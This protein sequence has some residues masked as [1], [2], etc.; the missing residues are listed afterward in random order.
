MTAKINNDLVIALDEL[1]RSA[2]YAW[3]KFVAELK[4]Y[5]DNGKDAVL[6]CPPGSPHLSFVQGKAVERRNFYIMAIN[7]Q[8]EAE[9]IRKSA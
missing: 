2:P 1:S 8:N 4:N 3:A 7:C 6:S 5:V 9:R